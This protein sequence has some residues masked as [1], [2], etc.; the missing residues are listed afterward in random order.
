MFILPAFIATALALMC[1]G[2]IAIA[3]LCIRQRKLLLDIAESRAAHQRVA[4]A[5][6]MLVRR[7]RLSAHDVRGVGM[8]LHGH[9]D[10]LV[11][12]GHTDA[13][14]I[15]TGAADLLDLADTLQ[16]LT[17]DPDA[18]RVLRDESMTLGAVV[19]EA[20][21]AVSMAILP[22]RRN[23]RIQPDLRPV[24][25][26]ADRRAVRHAIAR[27]L[28]DAV[29]GTRNDDWID[30]GG[31]RRAD[32]YA[33]SIAD[34][35]TGAQTPDAVARRQDS[36]GISLRLS[37]ARAL[38]EAHDGHLDV[39]AHAGVGSKV[40][41]VFPT[42]RIAAEVPPV[43]RPSHSYGGPAPVGGAPGR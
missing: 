31:E 36:R 20:I 2:A 10:H 6:A 17:T 9:A 34:E 28:A 43:S 12:A 25:L 23:W 39:E 13:A 30:V 21:G 18:P 37:L 27:I 26:C 15:A 24:R 33:L 14:G 16:D 8:T 5:H 41:L 40:S 22:G 38:V 42:R 3:F 29:R 19:D 35:G 7:M 4:E 11:A 32:G 1:G